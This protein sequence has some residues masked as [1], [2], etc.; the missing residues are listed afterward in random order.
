ML[1]KREQVAAWYETRLSGTPGI[2]IPVIEPSTTR[3][4]WFVYVVRFDATLD[5]DTLANR[6]G[7]K[8]RTRSSV[9]PADPFAALHGRAFRLAR[10]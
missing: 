5:R 6:L 4:S 1:A 2:E 7:E 9:L 3:M 10:G 8:E